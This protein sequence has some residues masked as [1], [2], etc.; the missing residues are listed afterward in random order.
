MT[1]KIVATGAAVL[2]GL[3]LAAPAQARN[4]QIAGLQVALRAYGLYQGP[5]DAIAG[6]MTVRAT[7]AFQR[8]AGLPVD[9]ATTR[10]VRP[11]R[12]AR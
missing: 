6:P 1:G 12:M 8:R 9:A 5:V 2:A 11:A 7:K 10:R 4:P 3:T